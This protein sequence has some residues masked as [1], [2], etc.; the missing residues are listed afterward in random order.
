[1]KSIRS[2]VVTE[3]HNNRTIKIGGAEDFK[4]VSIGIPVKLSSITFEEKNM[5]SYTK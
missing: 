2:I 4:R 5:Y 3:G 1:M